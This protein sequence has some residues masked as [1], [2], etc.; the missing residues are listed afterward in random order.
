[1]QLFTFILLIYFIDLYH[2]FN[3]VSYCSIHLFLIVDRFLA[4]KS[5][6]LRITV[7]TSLIIYSSC[8]TCSGTSIKIVSS[9]IRPKFDSKLL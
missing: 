3:C 4:M 5:T 9:D 7:I 1:M 2:K 8:E 6:V